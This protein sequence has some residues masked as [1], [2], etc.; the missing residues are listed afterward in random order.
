M[1]NHQAFKATPTRPK[2]AFRMAVPYSRASIS[3]RSAFRAAVAFLP[4]VTAQ[5]V[6]P[7]IVAIPN[8]L[9]PNP[10]WSPSFQTQYG[11]DVSCLTDLDP[12]LSL[13]PAL[14]QDLFHLMT[15][16]PGSLFWAPSTTFSI[17]NLLSTGITTAT[18][19]QV[20]AAIQAVMLNDER[21]LTCQV[22]V[23]F[24]GEETLSAKVSV[25]PATGQAF[26]YVVAI[27]K[28]QITLIS[29]GYV[30]Q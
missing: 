15:E 2:L 30:N 11:V 10:F 4:P 9:P 24:D 27:T 21:V 23:T 28:V 7:P 17:I 25:V 19:S 13:V 16:G 18:Q 14:P 5:P 12:Y 22:I 20:Q 1:A 3:L 26:Q 29:V 8:V 6:T